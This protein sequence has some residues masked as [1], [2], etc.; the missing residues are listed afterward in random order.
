MTSATR[1]PVWPPPATC[2]PRVGSGFT[3][4]GHGGRCSAGWNWRRGRWVHLRHRA[5]SAVS[6]DRADDFHLAYAAALAADGRFAE[7][8]QLVTG[9]TE[10]AAKLARSPL[11]RVVINY[12]AERWSDVVK[13]LSPSSTTPASTRP[14]RTPPRSRWASR[15]PGWDVA[16]ALSYLED[17]RPGRRRRGG[18]RAG[19]GAVAARRRRRGDRQRGPAGPVRGQSGER[20]GRSRR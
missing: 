6:R 10:R 2:L 15:W 9:V 16:P 4:R 17:P 19:E 13:L 3:H 7:A 5:V 8:R 14:S 11:G 12:R 1:G 18:R 20:A